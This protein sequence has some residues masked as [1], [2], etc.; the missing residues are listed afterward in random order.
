MCGR[1]LESLSPRFLLRQLL[2]LL[3]HISRVRLC[4]TPQ[5][6]AHQAPVPGI[7]QA[8]TLEWVAISFSIA[9]KW[10][11]KVKSLSR[12]QLFA[13]PW[14]AAHQA[15]LSMGFPRQEHWSGLPLPSPLRHLEV[16]KKVKVKSESCS[17]TSD[18]SNPMNY[19]VDGIL[20]TRILE[21]V[22][23]PFFRRSSQPRNWTQVS[24]LAGGFFTSWASRKALSSKAEVTS[25]LHLKETMKQRID[26]I[27][28]LTHQTFV[29]Q[30]FIWPLLHTF[31]SVTVQTVPSSYQTDTLIS[32]SEHKLRAQT[33]G[34]Y[35]NLESIM[36]S[37]ISQIETNSVWSHLIFGI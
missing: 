33:W 10:K 31:V 27:L 29:L 11:V 15:P 3:R 24:L 1:F 19:T 6:A 9:W 2:L 17:D 8:R 25:L 5:M 37:E 21:W 4:V 30:E 12:V 22:A 18:F 36:L 28:D 23:F 7:L 34:L 16:P 14:T 20:Q 35:A 26:K 32:L 13:T